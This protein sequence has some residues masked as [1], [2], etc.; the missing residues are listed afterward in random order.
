M[1]GIKEMLRLED[2]KGQKGEPVSGFTLSRK[3]L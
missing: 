1:I 2:Q 3:N